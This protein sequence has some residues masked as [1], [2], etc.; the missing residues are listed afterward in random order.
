MRWF[1]PK[2]LLYVAIFKIF[3][4]YAVFPEIE[5]HMQVLKAN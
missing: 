3:Y 4:L 5:C 2:Y 1:P